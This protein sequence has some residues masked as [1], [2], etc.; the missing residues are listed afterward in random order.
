MKKMIVIGAVILEKKDIFDKFANWVES[1]PLC[2]ALTIT[3]N[4]DII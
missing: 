3:A 1:P 4:L 2:K